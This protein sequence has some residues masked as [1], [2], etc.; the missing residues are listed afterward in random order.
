MSFVIER[1]DTFQGT[2]FRRVE[3]KLS[4][5]ARVLLMTVTGMK[6]LM[7]LGHLF[8]AICVLVY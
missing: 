8:P 2:S 6:D 1:L 7:K 3:K 5:H 4:Q